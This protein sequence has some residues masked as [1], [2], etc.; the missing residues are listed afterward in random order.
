[1]NLFEIA[2]TVRRNLESFVT[3]HEFN[4]QK[5]SK[6]TFLTVDV[7]S[8][9]NS[10]SDKVS[11]ETLNAAAEMFNRAEQNV[12]DNETFK[13]ACLE[14]ANAYNA[15]SNEAPNSNAKFI[16]NCLAS[17]AIAC[18]VAILVAVACG[19]SFGTFG[20]PVVIGA[21]ALMVMGTI[22]LFKNNPDPEYP[23]EG[24]STLGYDPTETGV[25][26]DTN[27][28]VSYLG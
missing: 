7:F 28:N 21:G 25:Q 12:A 1:M 23:D 27:G 24:G 6:N 5:D 15:Y 11:D 3:D 14:Q 8:D 4:Q 19:V 18:G 22:G 16:I 10:D 20:I 26:Y 13:K 9:P 2:T 17:A